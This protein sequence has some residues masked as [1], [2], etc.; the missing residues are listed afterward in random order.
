MIGVLQVLKN[1]LL[2]LQC[3]SPDKLC[4]LPVRGTQGPFFGF[5]K[6]TGEGRRGHILELITDRY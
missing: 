1:G 6:L 4:R 5:N 3:D 2:I